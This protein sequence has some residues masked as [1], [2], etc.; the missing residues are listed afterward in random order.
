VK[1]LVAD[2]ES[3]SLLIA[4]LALQT[5]GHQCRTVS[6]GTKAWEEFR[7]WRPDAVISDW[8]MPGLNGLELCRA[9]RAHRS[10]PYTY[11]IMVTGQGSLDQILEAMKVGADDYLVKPLNIDDFRARLIGAARV[12]TLHYQLAQQQAELR[13]LND[14]LSFMARKD[15]LTGLGNRRALQEALESL[16]AQV[17]RYGHSYCIALVDVDHFKAYNDA[18]GHQ[19]GDR[20]LEAVSAE[21]TSHARGGD[22]V[23][24]YGGD[25]FLCIFPE[26]SLATCY[27]TRSQLLRDSHVQRRLGRLGSE[28][29]ETGE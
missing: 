10:D 23:Y 4:E 7:S 13:R 20:I 22:S 5:L 3:T 12:T 2:D 21:L 6:D 26:Q 16:E 1:V 18:F 17:A 28:S 24:R 8:T 9:I 27:C 15:P 25:E 14:E 19:A 11:F 29:G